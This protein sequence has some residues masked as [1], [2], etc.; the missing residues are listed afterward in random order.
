MADMQLHVTLLM[1]CRRAENS[2][3]PDALGRA[4]TSAYVRMA[5]DHMRVAGTFPANLEIEHWFAPYEGES[6]AAA[7]CAVRNYAFI[8]QDSDAFLVVSPEQQA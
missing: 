4:R 6:Q 5:F 1:C 7:L 8:D 3:S 2:G